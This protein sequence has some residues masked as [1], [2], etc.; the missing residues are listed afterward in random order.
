MC[1]NKIL[2]IDTDLSPCDGGSIS[3]RSG[4]EEVV[5]TY[6][7]VPYCC[8]DPAEASTAQIVLYHSGEVRLNYRNISRASSDGTQFSR[9]IIVG[10]EDSTG[11][12]GAT[13]A[14]TIEN[15]PP[16]GSSIRIYSTGEKGASGSPGD[17]VHEAIVHEAMVLHSKTY[18][19]VDTTLTLGQATT[20]SA[21]VRTQY[22]APTDSADIF[23][24][25]ECEFTIFSSFDDPV[26]K[27]STWISFG[28]D[29]DFHR[30]MASWAAGTTFESDEP[31]FWAPARDQ[32]LHVTMVLY[33][34]DVKLFSSGRLVTIGHLESPINRVE[35][36]F[37]FVGASRRAPAGDKHADSELMISGFIIYDRSLSIPEVFATYSGVQNCCLFAAGLDDVFG[38]ATID[39]TA[40]AMAVM[41]P[42]SGPSAVELRADRSLLRNQPPSEQSFDNCIPS[43]GAGDSGILT[44][45]D[46]CSHHFTVDDCAGELQDGAGPYSSNE[47][48]VFRL[49][50]PPGLTYAVTVHE[51]DLE[52]EYDFVNIFDGD[53]VDAPSLA[54]LSGNSADFGTPIFTS[55]GSKVTIQLV[56][57]RDTE[58][59]GFR[60]EFRCVG[61]RFE[62]WKP[63]SVATQLQIG[64]PTSAFTL[65][66]QRTACF[67]DSLLATYCCADAYSDC[68]N[69]RVTGLNLNNVGLRG[70]VPAA[71]GDFTALRTIKLHDNFLSGTLPRAM[72]RLHRLEEL[73]LEHN[74]F[75]IQDTGELIEILAG[76]MALKTFS[77]GL[78]DERAD[79]S[80]S[81]LVPTPSLQCKVGEPCSV[82]IKTRNA[83]KLQLPHGGLRMELTNNVERE[84]VCV[85][86]DQMDGSYVSSMKKERTDWP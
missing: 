43:N 39:L 18:M 53:S 84:E 30:P 3:Y 13:I 16:D 86:E 65:G 25:G 38:V 21:W 10:Y 44:V 82:E 35:R 68:Q 58:G 28:N 17:I 48:C 42:S 61:L 51:M 15:G 60:I 26:A 2:L 74:Q 72:H 29:A 52:A 67:A 83:E 4:P 41:E 36:S 5:I 45:F 37:N 49:S 54:Q 12:L 27:E 59:Q 9:D 32:W 64:V 47:D 71:I 56:S 55:T 75:E 1:R 63:G 19:S 40:E 79:L 69:A 66:S 78:S 22:R 70:V 33:E 23:D 57:D 73:Q 31:E 85:C 11:T 76:F 6:D 62:P 20:I 14:D 7:N 8:G 50:G 81:I 34:L 77:L 46:I 24:G 80:K